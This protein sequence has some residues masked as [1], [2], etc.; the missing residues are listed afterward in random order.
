[1]TYY[2]TNSLPISRIASKIIRSHSSDGFFTPLIYYANKLLL[3]TQLRAT[4]EAF[5]SE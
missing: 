3:N 5:N 2:T 4:A 1:M